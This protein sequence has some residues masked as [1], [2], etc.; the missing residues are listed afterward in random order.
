MR[1]GIADA[2]LID[3]TSDTEIR[4]RNALT[5][6]LYCKDY[7]ALV[8]L[9]VDRNERNSRWNRNVH[10]NPKF[11]CAYGK[12]RLLFQRLLLVHVTMLHGCPRRAS[13]H[14]KI[15]LDVVDSVAIRQR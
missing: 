2:L 15:D 13:R 9:R 5:S 1:E 11:D 8:T 3:R 10:E 14:R 4:S 7:D 12:L 6:V